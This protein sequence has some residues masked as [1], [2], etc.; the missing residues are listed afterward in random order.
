M[1]INDKVERKIK[2]LIVDDSP[3]IREALKAILSSDIEIEV[4]GLAANGDEGVKKAA[5]LKPDVIT[6]DLKMPVMSGLEAVEKIMEDNPIPIIVVSSMDVDVVVKA[7]SIGAMDFV[8]I[9]SDIEKISHDLISKVKIA[10][11]VKPLRRMKIRPIVRT[12]IPKKENITKVVAVGV[13]TGGPQALQ[14]LLS[15][16]PHDL[17][18]GLIIVQ[19]ISAGF[20]NGLVEWLKDLTHL[21]I[22]VAQAGDVLK[23]GMV[24]FAPDGFN[25]L[26]D[27]Y[28]RISLK[29]DTTRKLIH[30][31]SIDVMMNSVA[32]SFGE[33]AIGIIMTGMGNDGVEGIKSIKNAGGITIAQNEA[34]SVIFGMNELAIESGCIDKVIP[35]NEIADEIIGLTKG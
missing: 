11:R 19:H 10:S 24:F 27:A 34:S 31:P 29:E 14:V 32:K 5:F 25:I 18:F 2:V 35:L 4:V 1:F 17:P 8:A 26:I 6:M 9:S 30:V 13:S 15:K 22:K 20:I 16:L 12:S 3:L 7:L 21:E 23:S 28:S 33:N